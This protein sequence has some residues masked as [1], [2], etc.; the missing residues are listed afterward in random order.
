MG[1]SSS[2]PKNEISAW[3]SEVSKQNP[4]PRCL[5]DVAITGQDGSNWNGETV[6]TPKDHATSWGIL[7]W[8]KVFK[9]PRVGRKQWV[10]RYGCWDQSLTNHSSSANTVRVVG[11]REQDYTK[12]VI[13][14]G[15]ALTYLPSQTSVKQRSIYQRIRSE[16]QQSPSWTLQAVGLLGGRKR[17]FGHVWSLLA[18]TAMAKTFPS[19]FKS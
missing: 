6:P 12:N 17:L 9:H 7:G 3:S 10:L 18:L 16:R 14:Q 5:S 1:S 15:Q 19:R 8:K 4:L 13:K 2:T 11:T